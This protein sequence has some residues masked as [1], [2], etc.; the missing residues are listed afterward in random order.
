MDSE[1]DLRNPA[2]RI[3]GASVIVLRRGAVLMVLRGRGLME[4]H[5]SFPGGRVE[6]GEDAE[7]AARR[8]LFE[9]TALT[10][11]SLVRLGAFQP[12]PDVS[13]LRLTV[14]AARAATGEPRAGDDALRA[15]FVPFHDVLQRRTTPG[16][17]GWI[18][19]ALIGLAFPPL[20]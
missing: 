17:P 2:E 9:E 7:A 6:A 5:W 11:G 16:A 15:E 3:E 20:R 18:A 4:G 10:V 8:E 12:A 14:F 19:R 13:P 1:R